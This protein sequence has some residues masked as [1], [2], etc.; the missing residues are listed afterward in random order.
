MHHDRVVMAT[1]DAKVHISRLFLIIVAF[2]PRF[3]I[4][5]HLSGTFN[6]KSTSQ[7]EADKLRILLQLY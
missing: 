1:R 4:Y 3:K 6:V 2:S 5:V 7:R